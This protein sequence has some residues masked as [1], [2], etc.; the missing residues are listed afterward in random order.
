M[1]LSIQ[2][3]FLILKKRGGGEPAPQTL[4]QFLS[5]FN[6][7]YQLIDPT[8]T[9]N[10]SLNAG[11]I[12]QVSDVSGNNMHILQATTTKQPLY[13]IG[14]LNGK[15]AIYFDGVNDCLTTANYS[16][17]AFTKWY[18]WDMLTPAGFIEEIGSSY[19][20]TNIGATAEISRNGGFTN[21]NNTASWG[22]GKRIV[23]WRFDGTFA[24]HQ[25]WVNGVL[26]RTST[27]PSN[28]GT[29]P[30]VATLNLGSR[31]NGASGPSKGFLA[32][33]SAYSRS[34]S[35]TEIANIFTRLNTEFNIY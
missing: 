18:V 2:Q 10:V 11:N 24:G 23:C 28:P 3:K 29:T 21:F 22:L 19:L 25:L 17:G 33:R 14:G 12:S 35:N 34:L 20:W 8:N 27:G 6:N 1:P 7:L 30:I 31:N 9:N 26:T 16:D 5:S 13:S 4:S 32:H 15:N